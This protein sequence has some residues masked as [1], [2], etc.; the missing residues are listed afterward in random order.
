MVDQKGQAETVFGCSVAATLTVLFVAAL[1]VGGACKVVGAGERGVVTNWSAPT[2]EI[3]GEGLTFVTPLIGNVEIMSVQ[4]HAFLAK[5]VEAASHDLQTVH[6]DVTINYNLEPGKVVEVY[7]TLRREYEERILHPSTQ[8]TVKAVTAQYPAES[9]ITK[10][11]EVRDRIEALLTAKVVGYGLAISTV[12]IT[13]F[14]FSEDFE[15][16]IEA[17]V[18]AEQQALKARND[19]E[20][21]K[22]EAEQR[23]VSARAEAESIRIR[24][25]AL[26]NSPK[27]VEWEAIQKWDGRLPQVSGGNTPFIDIRGVQR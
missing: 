14:S 1:L 27:L 19:L 18:T 23:V 12:S 16:A 17:K 20:R 11:A 25:E 7:R 2:G 6:T 10:R 22:T 21:I 13:Q 15:R 4:T 26:A 24:S 5:S 9:L 3:R 8:E